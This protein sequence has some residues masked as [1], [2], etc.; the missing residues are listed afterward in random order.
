MFT[1]TVINST[2]YMSDECREDEEQHKDNNFFLKHKYFTLTIISRRLDLLFSYDQ[3]FIKC[4][5]YFIHTL[6]CP[7]ASFLVLE[8]LHS[9][10]TPVLWH[11]K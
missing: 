1:V 3:I 7:Q 6:P 8:S 2:A 5:T 9:R 10:K 11:F 4:F